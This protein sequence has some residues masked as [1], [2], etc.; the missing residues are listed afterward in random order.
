MVQALDQAG[1]LYVNSRIT[2]RDLATDVFN[3]WY[4]GEHVPDVLNTGGVQCAFRFYTANKA[5]NTVERPY[6]ALYA[7]PNTGLL[8]NTTLKEVPVHSDKLPGPTKCIFD[9]AEFDVRIYLTVGKTEP[10][11]DGHGK[12]MPRSAETTGDCG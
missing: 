6:L 8:I 9:L 4:S 10:R 1:L 11:I 3:D 2:S 7:A 12:I 5:P